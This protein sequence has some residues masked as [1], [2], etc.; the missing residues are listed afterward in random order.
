M[1]MFFPQSYFIFYSCS[2]TFFQNWE[3][4]IAPF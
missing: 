4:V 3:K 2:R 1:F